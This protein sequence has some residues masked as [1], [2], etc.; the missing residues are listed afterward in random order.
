MNSLIIGGE[1]DNLKILKEIW[2]GAAKKLSRKN[3]FFYLGKDNM[4]MN[5]TV[6]LGLEK[7]TKKNLR[8]RGFFFHKVQF[9]EK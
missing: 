8:I 1:N 3:V 5:L 9:L 4:S 2:Y 6:R 7:S